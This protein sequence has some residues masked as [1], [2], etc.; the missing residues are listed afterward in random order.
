MYTR[1]GESRL[2]C[3]NYQGW[4]HTKQRCKKCSNYG[5]Q[6]HLSH[7]CWEKNKEERRVV[8]AFEQFEVDVWS[9]VS[10]EPVVEVS[11][12][13]REDKTSVNQVNQEME[14][15]RLLHIKSWMGGNKI[16][17]DL[18]ID[19]SY[20]CNLMSTT[21]CKKLGMAVVPCA[22]TLFRFS[23]VASKTV[24]VTDVEPNWE[25]GV[26]CYNST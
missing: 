17:V 22:K 3:G 2:R 4:G 12:S 1:R 14:R 7:L 19:T 16:G 10:V 9:F 21:L 13:R 11:S 18:L 5:N 20:A 25:I 8:N 24:G 6:G 23:E 15:K 26:K